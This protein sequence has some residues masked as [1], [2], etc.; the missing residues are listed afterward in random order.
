MIGQEPRVE[1]YILIRPGALGDALLA[2]PALALLRR[3]RPDAHVTLVARGDVLPLAR[4]SALA[5]AV[6][7]WSDPLWAALFADDPDDL[8]AHG[9]RAVV[10]GAAVVAWLSEEDGMVTR[11]LAAWG[12]WQVVVAPGRPQEDGAAPREHTALLLA[13]A[14]A[15]L[16][17]AVPATAQVL[18]AGM[19]SLRVD[20]DDAQTAARVWDALD[21]GTQESRPV[22]ALHPGSGGS[23]K[24]WPP[25]RFAELAWRLIA[26]GYWVLLVEGPAD[27][28]VTAAVQAALGTG[29][30][31]EVRIA[32]RLGIGALAALL[33]RC[34]A[35][36]GNDSG[37]SHLAALAGMPTLALFG[38]SDPARWAPLGP[39]VRVVRGPE[40]DLAALETSVVWEALLGLRV[41]R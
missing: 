31:D 29:K 12:A 16:G 26:G 23:A 22:V 4:A 33:R 30:A 38:P 8:P 27:M 24:R 34:A 41:R 1:R 11:N 28:H 32:R 6:F 5:D 9:A 36:V 39:Q 15:P 10:R 37:V 13:R 2:L 3:V 35:Y 25:E 18:A 7:D 17:I 20:E 19:P 14:L 40:G 21:L